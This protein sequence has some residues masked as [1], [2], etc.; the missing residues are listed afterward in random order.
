MAQRGN[1]RI[2]RQ[3]EERLARQNEER[4]ARQNEERLAR[5]NEERL[6]RDNAFITDNRNLREL[7]GNPRPIRPVI[8]EIAS[9][10]GN[11]RNVVTA[12]FFNSRLD[13]EVYRREG[14]PELENDEKLVDDIRYATQVQHITANGEL[15]FYNARNFITDKYNPENL[16]EAQNISDESPAD[17]DDEIKIQ[18]EALRLGGKYRFIYKKPDITTRTGGAFLWFLKEKFPFS[19]SKYGIYKKSEWAELKDIEIF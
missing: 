9:D 7:G 18:L 11:E 15:E 10:V 2:Q 14:F 17:P 6:A 3:N 5:Q 8:T 1:R 12:E 13:P 16:L 4:L 19:L